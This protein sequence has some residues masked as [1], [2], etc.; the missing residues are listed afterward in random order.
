ML[1]S[2]K[3]LIFCLSQG[4]N[5][6]IY[7]YN[8]K[9]N[10]SGFRAHKA[11]LKFRLSQ[12]N[13]AAWMQTE[14]ITIECDSISHIEIGARFVPDYQ[15]PLFAKVPYTSADWLSTEFIPSNTYFKRN[16]FYQR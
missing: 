4:I 8:E 1:K 3:N 15:I 14:G 12:V 6:K 5:V 16:I 13:L 7:N 9:K 11:R 10:T 2:R